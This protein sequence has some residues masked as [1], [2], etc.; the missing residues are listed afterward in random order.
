M[1]CLELVYLKRLDASHALPVSTNAF[2]ATHLLKKILR[3]CSQTLVF[4]AGNM[5]T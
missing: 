3:C 1:P 2:V 5:K 4:T